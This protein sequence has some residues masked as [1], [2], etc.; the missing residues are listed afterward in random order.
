MEFSKITCFS[1]LQFP[2]QFS[3]SLKLEF[4]L[5][6]WCLLDPLLA[7]GLSVN[8]LLQP[9]SLAQFKLAVVTTPLFELGQTSE[10]STQQFCSKVSML[11]RV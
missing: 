8:S 2:S 4:A 10:D 1:L 6:H 9:I 3:L 5:D 7:A 11:G